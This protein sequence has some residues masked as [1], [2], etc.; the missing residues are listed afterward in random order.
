MILFKTL[1][2]ARLATVGLLTMAGCR[3]PDDKA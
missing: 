2:L 1:R 3:R